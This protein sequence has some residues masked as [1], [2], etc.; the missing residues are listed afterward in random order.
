VPAA[1]IACRRCGRLVSAAAPRCPECRADPRDGRSSYRDGRDC[2][3]VC[4]GVG[5]RLL[6]L[7]LDSVI[8]A[9]AFLLV[10]LATFLLLAA[11][12]RFAVVGEEPSPAPLWVVF[13]VAGFIYF[14]AC[15]AR[16]GRT[17]GKRFCDLRVVHTDG[18]SIGYG[19]A[20]VRSLLRV[21]DF[22]PAGYLVA[23]VLVWA[24]PRRQRLGDI[25]ARTVVVRPVTVQ[26]EDAATARL[27][28]VPW[29]S[30]EGKRSSG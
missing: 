28:I 16:W 10:A 1:Q 15:E 27:P 30:P 5:A 12:S 9:A 29:M 20:F 21:V 8:L 14:W 22:L 19:A 18:S 23:A 11:D 17:I 25:A 4:Q 2:V 24:T 6:A 7:A 26:T 13:S 3:R